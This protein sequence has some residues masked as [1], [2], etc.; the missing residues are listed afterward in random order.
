[1]YDSSALVRIFPRNIKICRQRLSASVA[2]QNFRAEV[3]VKKA[4]NSLTLCY[5]WIFMQF[6][7]VNISYVIL[8][9]Q[10]S[11]IFLFVLVRIWFQLSIVN[12]PIN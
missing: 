5:N 9:S 6:V 7:C 8:N 10:F 4:K 12:Q 1:M 3:E 11:L 2:S